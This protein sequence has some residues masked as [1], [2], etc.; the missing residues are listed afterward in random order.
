MPVDVKSIEELGEFGIISLFERET[1]DIF[2]HSSLKLI[3]R[4]GDDCSVFKLDS[5]YMVVTTD[6]LLEDVHFELFRS[7][8]YTLGRKSLAV[9]ISDIAAMGAKPTFFLLSVGLPSNIKIE[10]LY[11]FLKG[12]RESAKRWGVTLIGGDTTSSR[13]GLVISITMFGESKSVVFRSGAKPGDKIYIS[14]HLGKSAMGLLILKE[15][16]DLLDKY[17]DLVESHIDPSPKV[18]LAN[19]L[20]EKKL[21]NSMMDISDGLS[22]DLSHIC[23]ESGVRGIIEKEKIPLDESL[24]EATSFLSIS[25]LDLFLHG[26][27]D[28]ELLFTSSE[29]NLAETVYKEFGINIYE[30]GYISHGNG[31]FIKEKEKIVPLPKRGFDH[32]RPHPTKSG[33]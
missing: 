14:G 18:E 8:L 6:M 33:K 28:F 7:D 4:I 22:I 1:K 12:L 5:S 10:S 19:F 16:K 9:N 17:K 32:F 24:C 31:I 3:K 20:S 27:E 13:S 15:R 29:P 30:I 2:A 21:V 26:G 11:S 23:D 25:P